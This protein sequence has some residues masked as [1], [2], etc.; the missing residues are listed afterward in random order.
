[1]M[2][3][4]HLK[5]G[6]EIEEKWPNKIKVTSKFA[7][8]LDTQCAQL[9]DKPKKPPKGGIVAQLTGIPIEIDD[10]IKSEYYKFVY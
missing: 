9:S 7:N 8:Y 5:M 6:Y 2:F 3:E 4:E 10:A 1:M